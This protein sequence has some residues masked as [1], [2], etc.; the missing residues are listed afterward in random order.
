MF[1][2]SCILMFIIRTKQSLQTLLL[3]ICNIGLRHSMFAIKLCCF[4][5]HWNWIRIWQC[6]HSWKLITRRWCNDYL[7]LYHLSLVGRFT[8][9]VEWIGAYNCVD[10]ALVL[11]SIVNLLSEV[12]SWICK[13]QPC[14]SPT[15]QRAPLQLSPANGSGLLFIMF[16]RPPTSAIPSIFWLGWSC[17]HCKTL[18]HQW[19]QDWNII[20]WWFCKD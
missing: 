16:T 10:P 18:K 8:P 11:T 6:I 13:G 12:E 4:A 17:F 1:L 9:L 5:L 3:H 20:H 15:E 14:H 19:H 7:T 2:N